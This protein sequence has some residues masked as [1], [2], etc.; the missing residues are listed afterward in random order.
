MAETLQQPHERVKLYN[1]SIDNN[2][3]SQ[4]GSIVLP[5]EVKRI[6]AICADMVNGTGLLSIYNEKTNEQLLNQHRADDSIRH[7]N[8]KNFQL[9]SYPEGSNLKYTFKLLESDPNYK[10]E[11]KL[12]ITYEHE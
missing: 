3:T 10:C 7:F 9:L 2:F 11:L 6:V 1:I 5:H 4:D 12:I 8:K